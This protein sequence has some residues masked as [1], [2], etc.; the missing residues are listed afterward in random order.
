[1]GQLVFLSG[2]S[3]PRQVHPTT[4]VKAVRLR[5]GLLCVILFEIDRREYVV[6]SG[7][8]ARV[9]HGVS[10]AVLLLWE[11]PSGR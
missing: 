2:P 7:R 11:H 3:S 8:W 9:G 10:S 6:R 1:V 5:L 4:P